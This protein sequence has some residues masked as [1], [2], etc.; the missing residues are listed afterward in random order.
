[1]TDNRRGSP[2]IYRGAPF[3]GNL[4][5]DGVTAALTR[6]IR[7]RD[8]SSLDLTHFRLKDSFVESKL[9]DPV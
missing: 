1:M 5:A 6:R 7:A 3:A 8:F 4:H 9:D 2:Q